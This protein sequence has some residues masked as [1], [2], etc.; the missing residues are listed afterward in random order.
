MQTR[1]TTTMP[2]WSSPSRVSASRVWPTSLR[3]ATDYQAD[4][5]F[6][7]RRISGSGD[8]SVR[9]PPVRYDGDPWMLGVA[10]LEYHDDRIA[11]E[12]IYVT[13]PW[14]APDWRAQWRSP[15]TAIWSPGDADGRLTLVRSSG[16]RR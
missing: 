14:D 4:V 5:E 3:G 12:R 15:T 10:T 16:Q 13:E 1:S 11:L 2:S 7:V 6:Q 9:E 8:V